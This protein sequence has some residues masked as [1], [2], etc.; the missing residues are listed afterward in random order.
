MQTKN[1]R[2]RVEMKRIFLQETQSTNEYAKALRGLGKNALVVAERQTGGRGTKGRS[3]S[4]QKGGV[5]LSLL[6]FYQDFPAL[7]AFQIMQGAAAAVCET[8]ALFGVQPKIKWPN[9]V[10]V[11]GKKICGILIENALK[12]KYIASSV[13]GIGLNVS[14]QLPKQLADIATTLY[15][16]TGKKIGVQGVI[17]TLVRFLE[18]ENIYEK[19]EKHLGWLGEEITLVIGETEKKAKLLSVDETGGLWAEVN[20][21]KERFVAA[22]VSLRVVKES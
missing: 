19:Y 9:D 22:E 12:G 18:E 7:N 10:Y 3:F 15:K 4:S 14:N 1:E 20:G 21:E 6:K 11:N 5:Y 16:E 13:V 17:D 8:L 2:G